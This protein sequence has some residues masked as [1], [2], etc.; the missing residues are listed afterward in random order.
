MARKCINDLDLMLF[1]AGLTEHQKLC[2][3]IDRYLEHNGHVY[4]MGRVEPRPI[5]IKR[6]KKSALDRFE[7]EEIES[8]FINVARFK[9]LGTK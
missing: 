7:L 1:W 6:I 3:Y 5:V 4:L 9:I 2:M 8:G